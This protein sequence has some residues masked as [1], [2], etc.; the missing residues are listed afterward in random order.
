MGDPTEL[1]GKFFLF[2]IEFVY[3]RTKHGIS[4]W[5]YPDRIDPL[6]VAVYVPSSV[7]VDE[8]T[9]CSRIDAGLLCC[10]NTSTE[11][12]VTLRRKS[13]TMERSRPNRRH[14]CR[15]SRRH[16][17][18]CAKWRATTAYIFYNFQMKIVCTSS[19]ERFEQYA[20]DFIARA[21]TRM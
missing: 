6:C 16:R 14:H 9:L 8:F 5:E 7:C 10:V 12:A 1:H 20:A 15:P 17:N 4:R 3:R 21:D 11:R 2:C 18:F 19:V 13:V